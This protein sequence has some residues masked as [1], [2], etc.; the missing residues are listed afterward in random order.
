M[1][2]RLEAFQHGSDYLFMTR[3]I[4]LIVVN[5]IH[6]G[7]TRVRVPNEVRRVTIA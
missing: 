1:I 7:T 5:L 6:P 4:N 3:F 2:Q